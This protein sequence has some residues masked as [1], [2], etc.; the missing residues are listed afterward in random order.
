VVIRTRHPGLG[1]L[2]RREPPP[3]KAFPIIWHGSQP[4]SGIDLNVIINRNLHHFEVWPGLRR[5]TID[6]SQIT[7]EDWS[8]KAQRLKSH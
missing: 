6:E 4:N 8:R 1:A 5:L 2:Y 3:W 7:D